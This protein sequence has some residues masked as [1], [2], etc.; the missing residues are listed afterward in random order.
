MLL[1]SLSNSKEEESVLAV[2]QDAPPMSKMQY[3]NLKKYDEAVASL[4]KPT[5]EIAEEYMKQPVKK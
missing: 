1:L 4:S 3:G 5:K 2:G